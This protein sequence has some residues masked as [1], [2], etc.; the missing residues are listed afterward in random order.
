MNYQPTRYLEA[1]WLQR[2]LP[3]PYMLKKAQREKQP[4]NW[5][6]TAQT[7]ELLTI[8]SGEGG[9][10]KNSRANNTVLMWQRR[11]HGSDGEG[12]NTRDFPAKPTDKQSQQKAVRQDGRT[13]L[14]G[15][16]CPV[17]NSVCSALKT[18][19]LAAPPILT[20]FSMLPSALSPGGTG[21]IIRMLRCGVPC[22]SCLSTSRSQHQQ[23]TMVK[24][25]KGFTAASKIQNEG[26]LSKRQTEKYRKFHSQNSQEGCNHHMA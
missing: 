5:K 15:Q 6:S 8:W 11:K 14:P 24:L 9:K 3:S 23:Q 18:L 4:M 2:S 13:G 21:V 22:E 1:L 19:T 16:N 26:A 25:Y 17:S 20:G 7:H 12:E 10:K